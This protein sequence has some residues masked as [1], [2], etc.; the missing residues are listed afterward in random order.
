MDHWPRPEDIE[1]YFL[2]P[3]GQRWFFETGNDGAVF[4]AK[5][6][7][8][9]DKLPPEQG[10]TYLELTMDGDPDLGVLLGW[11]KWNRHQ[12]LYYYSKG[13]LARLREFVFTLH[14]DARPAGLYIPFDQAWKAVK[15]FL[16]TDGQLPKSIEWVDARDLPEDT[17]L[18]PAKDWQKI[19]A[20]LKEWRARR[21]R[22]H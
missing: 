11:S 5:G 13:D 22:A 8:G 17:F 3:P 9:S 1:H 14:G 4:N 6:V 10:L 18:D 19:K 15:E 12:G 7:D 20:L 2:E 21:R 16:Q